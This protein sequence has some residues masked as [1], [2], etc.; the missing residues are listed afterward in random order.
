MSNRFFPPVIDQSVNFNA[1]VSG[2]TAVLQT[3]HEGIEI[4]LQGPAIPHNKLLAMTDGLVHFEPGTSSSN[5]RLALQISPPIS[6]VIRDKTPDGIPALEQ[7]NYIGVDVA[8]VEQAM[9]NVIA[10]TSPSLL[11]NIWQNAGTGT[12]PSNLQGDV[13]K[14]FMRQISLPAGYTPTLPVKAGTHIGAAAKLSAN[15]ANFTLQLFDAG[16]NKITP[17]AY[18]QSMPQIDGTAKYK[19]H[20]LIV[21]MSGGQ[22]QPTELFL[23]LE[24]YD[25]NQ[26]KHVPI[27]NVTVKVM[28]PVSVLSDN[29]LKSASTASDG[30]VA[31]TFPADDSLKGKNFYFL[32]DLSNLS[33]SFAGH[34]QIPSEWSTSGWLAADNST[35]G[36]YTKFPGFRVGADGAPATFRVGVDVHVKVVRYD[37]D[38]D[39]QNEN[40]PKP[41]FPGT[42]VFLQTGTFNPGI[43]NG[44]E[45]EVKKGLAHGV[46]FDLTGGSQLTIIAYLLIDVPKLRA[47]AGDL[48]DSSQ[49]SSNFK[50]FKS[51]INIASAN[52][53]SVGTHSQ[54]EVLN[55]ANKYHNAALFE[56]KTLLELVN[57]LDEITG[58][59]SK[60]L[61][62]PVVAGKGTMILTHNV[63]DTLNVAAGGKVRPFA[64][65]KGFIH[66]IK[67]SLPSSSDVDD[68][69]GTVF[70][71]S[72]HQ[73]TYFEANLSQLLIG[74]A[75]LMISEVGNITIGWENK[76]REFLGLEKVEQ[77][78]FGNHLVHAPDYLTNP[79]GTLVEAYP[80]FMATILNYDWGSST[81]TPDPPFTMNHN[82]ILDVRKGGGFTRDPSQ[83]LGPLPPS[84]PHQGAPGNGIN[85]EG[86]V[87]NALFDIF[88]YE[89]IDPVISIRN[90]TPPMLPQTDDGDV[91][92]ND[93]K[94]WITNTQVQ[95]RFQRLLWEPMTDLATVSGPV[96]MRTVFGLMKQKNT[97]DWHRILRWLQ[98]WNIQIIAP[99]ITNIQPNSGAAGRTHNVVITGEDFVLDETEVLIFDGASQVSATTIVKSHTEL[100]AQLPARPASGIVDVKV[101]VRQRGSPI[102][103][104]I[105]EATT[106]FTYT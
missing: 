44:V 66:F 42:S 63:I 81:S 90:I 53:T 50:L 30:T 17:E 33:G 4:S 12:S 64:F 57:F 32:A 54:P 2:V 8:A 5:A 71:E 77:F 76:A 27:P 38:A 45:V 34:N 99:Q 92:A 21:Q 91:V 47:A 51:A 41:I 65:P 94:N 83:R 88:V 80:E 24:I 67:H 52:E 89:V 1:V 49:V 60:A 11:K 37:S 96:S 82:T 85:V 61:H 13:L 100:E 39:F 62:R 7:I 72:T 93:P 105:G 74:P 23:R 106:T 95:S 16:S 68:L 70:H 103:Y 22:P 25:L 10:N 98:R 84:S 73:V 69:R 59:S 3:G 86:A 6:S 97:S 40:N 26:H 28:E 58:G 78:N 102:N 101:V 14:V 75:A 46:V 104:K 43:L 19:D 31:F 79:R 36:D 29:V 20:P 15:R 18:I 48:K 56:L 9:Q 35:P 55:P 87:V